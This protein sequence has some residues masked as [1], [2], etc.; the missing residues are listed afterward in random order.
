M[1]FFPSLNEFNKKIKNQQNQ[2]VYTK[3]SDDLDTPVSLIL[4]LAKNEKNSF[5]L[6]S[7][8][9]GEIKGRYSVLGMKPDLIW[10]SNLKESKINRNVLKKSN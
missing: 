9:G 8:T 2:I 1:D 3:F 6:E 4:K 7:V 5:L 10:K